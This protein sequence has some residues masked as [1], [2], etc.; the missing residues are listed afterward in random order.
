Y[1]GKKGKEKEWGRKWKMR[2]NTPTPTR[3]DVPSHEPS[4]PRGGNPKYLFS[5]TLDSLSPRGTS[6]GRVGEGGFLEAPPLPG[7]LLHRME[8]RERATLTTYNPTK[9]RQTA[10]MRLAVEFRSGGAG[11]WLVPIHCSGTTRMKSRTLAR[12]PKRPE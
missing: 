2:R 1:G 7:P 12:A 8:E 9:R 10:A 4:P 6:G 11:P 5:P 3:R